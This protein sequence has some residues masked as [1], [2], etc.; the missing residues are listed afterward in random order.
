MREK[1]ETGIQ[2]KTRDSNMELLRIVA[3]A[4]VL[5]NHFL[6]FVVRQGTIAKE[7]FDF[8]APMV[9]FGVN[10]FFMI[11]GWF[12]IRFSF[13]S[14]IKFAIT[15]LLFVLVNHLIAFPIVG[16]E[17]FDKF[18]LH[19]LFPISH[20][21]YWFIKV[22]LLLIVVAPVLNAGLRSLPIGLLRV[23]I[24]TF[25]LFTVY[26]CAIGGNIVNENGLNFTHGF[27][28]YCIGYYLRRDY[29]LFKGLNQSRRLMIVLTLAL[30]AT[31]GACLT[32]VWGLFVT[33]PSAF[34]ILFSTALFLLFAGMDFH[35]KAVNHIATAALGC[36]L[37]QDG[38]FG[39]HFLYDRMHEM[40]IASYSPLF[41]IGVFVGV[42]VSI[43]IVSILISPIIKV[44]ADRTARF[45]GK[46]TPP[47]G[48]F[49][50]LYINRL[51][52]RACF[53]TA[54]S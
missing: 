3:I 29:N 51:Q 6:F 39:W 37:L 4:A 43:W 24:A 42:F 20:S 9:S 54:I 15:I 32:H 28:M 21:P 14:I 2:K 36:Y 45:I 23:F 48:I 22:Y 53:L 34:N 44:I 7:V 13:R 49:K 11:S 16:G 30:T 8:C 47:V 5:C 31:I 25:V 41:K 27:L 33:Y 26:S 38:Y 18:Y 12:L 1:I 50:L 10:L 46:I 17:C 19:V 35:S 40:F 52:K